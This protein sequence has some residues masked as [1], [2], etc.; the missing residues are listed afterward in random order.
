M[1]SHVLK[2]FCMHPTSPSTTGF[3]RFLTVFIVL[4]IFGILVVTTLPFLI[5]MEF[6]RENERY[7]QCQRHLRY[8]CEPSVMWMLRGLMADGGPS[9]VPKAT[10]SVTPTSTPVSSPLGDGT[11]AVPTDYDD[12]LTILASSSSKSIVRPLI[13]KFKSTDLVRNGASYR[14]NVGAKVSFTL[15]TQGTKSGTISIGSTT[16]SA[17]ALKRVSSGVFRGTVKLPA[18]LPTYLYIVLKN[19][20][21]NWT[22]YRL[23]VASNQ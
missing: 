17:I 22:Q 2:C 6:T 14:A 16:S 11:D 12:A 13:I 23:S 3:P 4:G 21:G 10:I 9:A 5:A 7:D 19:G 18:T 8:D 1:M 20:E 15:E